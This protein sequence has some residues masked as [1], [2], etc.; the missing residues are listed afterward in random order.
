MKKF[1]VMVLAAMLICVGIISV[2]SAEK[3][4]YKYEEL[5]NGNIKITSADKSITEAVIPAEIDGHKVTAIGE[6]AF[7]DCEALTNVV[8]PDTVTSVGYQ[9][10][11]GCK[12]LISVTIP[13][14]VTEILA[15]TFSFCF[16]LKEVNLPETLTS[17]GQYAF[18][19]CY[20]LK[21]INIPDS[22]I[23]IS[24]GAFSDCKSLSDIIISP[25][26]P[27][28][29]FNSSAL[30][31]KMDMTLLRYIGRGVE[32]Y[33]IPWGIKRIGVGAF[34]GSALI[35]V[36][37]PDSVT[38]IGHYAFRDMVYLAELTIP[39]GVT[40][41]GSQNFY[42]NSSM[43]TI[44][45]PA[46]LVSIP[47]GIFTHCNKLKAIE[48]DPGNPVYEMRGNMLVNKKDNSVYYHMDRDTGTFEIPDGIEIIHFSA[49]EYNE[50]L[51]EIIIPDSV[52]EIYNSAFRMCHKLTGVRLPNGLKVIDSSVF[53]YCNSLQSVTIPEGVISIGYNAFND[54]RRLE[55][56][57]LPASITSIADSAFDGCEKLVCKVAED[58]YAQKFCEE[59]GVSYEVLAANTQEASVEAPVAE[60]A[61]ESQ[62]SQPEEPLFPCVYILQKDGT[63]QIT[64]VNQNIVNAVIPAE[65]DGYTVT[66][67]GN[68]AFHGCTRLTSVTIPDTVKSIGFNAFWSCTSLSEIN[69]PDSV[70]TICGFAFRSCR[71]LKSIS[72]P[73]SVIRIADGAFSSCTSLSNIDISP[74]HPVYAFSN[75]MLI[76]K[77]DM[78]LV[79]YLGQGSETCD[80]PWGIKEIGQGAFENTK[81]SSVI[82]PDSVTSIGNFAF[83]GMDKLKEIT[84]PDSVTSIGFQT[85]WGNRSMTAVRIP[86]SLTVLGFG[87]FGFCDSLNTIE[88]D[89]ENPVYEMRGSMLVNKK[90]NVLYYHLDQDEGTFEIPEGIELIEVDAFEKNEKLKEIIIPDTVKEIKNSAFSYCSNLT[91]IRL[92]KDIDTIEAYTFSSCDKLLSVTIPE[93][94]HTIYA[95]AF[96]G[97]RSLKEVVIPASVTNID[98]TAFT[99]CNKLVCKVVEGSYAQQFCEANR[100]TYIIQ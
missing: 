45:I 50:K 4:L 6:K 98:S 11:C 78:T 47:A 38:S 74:N 14:S 81:L 44:R 57:V 39:E 12:N 68:D 62:D 41:I 88:I 46:S 26:H 94:V 85:F 73:D 76:T 64:E 60:A 24:E 70:T 18:T 52:K 5:G 99:D 22:V 92:P 63:I 72:I 20:N 2:S 17:I 10:F 89:P 58:S 61:A 59:H 90:E 35:S 31:C 36:I 40:S 9:A 56:L 95:R 8:I 66:S 34:E 93:G 28:Y 80:I 51:H 71:S 1:L 30:I 87:S 77:K 96:E 86:A 82:I 79:Q 55:E 83:R 27:V 16:N 97:C 69:I 7:Y 65:I 23:D 75:G 33:E 48:I 13:E 21:S 29:T 32:T 15:N 54:C 91:G 3:E 49:F 67:I 100:I 43:T 53:E 19:N 37:I 42:G 25:N 84:I